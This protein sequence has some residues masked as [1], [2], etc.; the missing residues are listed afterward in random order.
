MPYKMNDGHAVYVSSFSESQMG[1]TPKCK[2]QK[3][4][5]KTTATTPN[6]ALGVHASRRLRRLL[7]APCQ[8]LIKKNGDNICLC[9]KRIHNGRS[10]CARARSRAMG[11]ATPSMECRI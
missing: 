6:S 11:V 4:K 9:A 1:Q 2:L 8:K 3:R 7:Y 10:T 5:K